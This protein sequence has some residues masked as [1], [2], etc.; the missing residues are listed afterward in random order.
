MIRTTIALLVTIVAVC[1]LPLGVQI[2]LFA[3]AIGVCSYRLLLLIPAILADVLYAPT[4]SIAPNDLSM[5]LLVGGLI[6]L[7]FVLTRY[8]RLGD[9]YV[10]N[11]A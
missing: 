1:W 2:G 5:T 9:Y 3:I 8:T 7:W 11:Q 4:A 6:I 10:S